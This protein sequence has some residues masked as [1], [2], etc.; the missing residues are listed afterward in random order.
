MTGVA[1]LV[2]T[3]SYLDIVLFVEEEVLHRNGAMKYGGVQFLF[4]HKPGLWLDEINN[5]SPKTLRPNIAKSNC[6][7]ENITLSS[8]IM[9][10]GCESDNN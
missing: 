5:N 2:E 6:D 7:S 4:F 3:L 1:T 10:D 9:E 8:D